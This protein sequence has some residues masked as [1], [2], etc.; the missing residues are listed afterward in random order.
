MCDG[1]NVDV[2]NV[3]FNSISCAQNI[4]LFSFIMIFILLRFHDNFLQIKVQ[5]FKI[6]FVFISPNIPW[7]M[8]YD[9]VP[10]KPFQITP[11][12]SYFHT[13]SIFTFSFVFKQ[14][15]E[16][17]D[18]WFGGLHSLSFFWSP[19]SRSESRMQPWVQPTWTAL[20]TENAPAFF[21]HPQSCWFVCFL[22]LS[23]EEWMSHRRLLHHRHIW[24]HRPAGVPPRSAGGEH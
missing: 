17:K 11:L 10:C 21:I 13:E 7:N 20:L 6:T 1:E 16:K 9:T 2:N 4:F 5:I 19:D 22:V 15:G 8:K 23:R 12:F 3:A 18:A 14:T 24:D